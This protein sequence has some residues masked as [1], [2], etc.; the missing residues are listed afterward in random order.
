MKL[1]STTSRSLSGDEI[2]GLKALSSRLSEYSRI[3][4]SFV[5]SIKNSDVVRLIASG[6]LMKKLTALD[7]AVDKAKSMEEF[8]NLLAGKAE[9]AGKAEKETPASSG[10]E[11]KTSL[12][13]NVV[14]LKRPI[15]NLVKDI[16]EQAGAE[17]AIPQ[18]HEKAAALSKAQCGLEEVKGGQSMRDIIKEALNESPSPEIPT[19]G[20]IAAAS[21]EGQEDIS[22]VTILNMV[23]LGQFTDTM[24]GQEQ[25]IT[26]VLS[27]L[28][29]SLEAAS[30]SKENAALGEG[31]PILSL[32]LRSKA[33]DIKQASDNSAQAIEDMKKQINVALQSLKS[34]VDFVKTNSPGQPLQSL[35]TTVDALISGIG[36]GT[37]DVEMRD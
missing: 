15:D 25:N 10:A 19:T 12:P 9:I 2:K 28:N 4:A 37:K 27:G 7:E 30:G 26:A 16:K 17:P 11:G 24:L 8:N 22:L 23:N 1:A 5:S 3:I 36:E 35:Q 33:A 21:Q 18:V 14:K 29:R 13:S 34:F 20:S 31:S 6:E 32:D